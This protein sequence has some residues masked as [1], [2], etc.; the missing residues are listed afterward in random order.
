MSNLRDIK[1][2]PGLGRAMGTDSPRRIRTGT[3]HNS[4]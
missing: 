3:P 1:H 2:L 4:Q